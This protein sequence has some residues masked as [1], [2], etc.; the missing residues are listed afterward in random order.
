MFALSLAPSRSGWLPPR[1]P[2][3]LL[4]QAAAPR[5]AAANATIAARLTPGAGMARTTVLEGAS[6]TSASQK[7]HTVSLDRM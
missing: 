7:G 5:L 2:V 1:G 6:A 3:S 4:L